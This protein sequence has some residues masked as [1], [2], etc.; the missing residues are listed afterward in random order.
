MDEE[1]VKAALEAADAM[2]VDAEAALGALYE[3]NY[4]TMGN[5]LFTSITDYRSKREAIDQS[6]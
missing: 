6:V 1:Q 3:E 5:D 4:N 2:A